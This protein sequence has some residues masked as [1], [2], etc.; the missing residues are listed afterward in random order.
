M[1]L[2][3]KASL[4]PEQEPNA[5]S[6]PPMENGGVHLGSP[7]SESFKH[8]S[9]ATHGIIIVKVEDNGSRPPPYISSS[10]NSSD[11]ESHARNIKDE[12]SGL[13]NAPSIIKR[14]SNDSLVEK[15]VSP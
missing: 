14:T 4:Q 9:D 8:S 10:V 15:H 6:A 11:S 1:D 5:Q 13:P 12:V 3:E 2:V 7:N